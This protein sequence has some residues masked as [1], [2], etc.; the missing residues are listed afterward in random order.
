MLVIL[1]YG[2]LVPPVCR[3]KDETLYVPTSI[4]QCSGE[5]KIHL[6]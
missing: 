3:V 5:L 6:T 2:S 1:A 4:N